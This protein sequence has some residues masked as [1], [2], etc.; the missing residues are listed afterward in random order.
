MS[1]LE[2]TLDAPEGWSEPAIIAKLGQFAG[3]MTQGDHPF[4]RASHA[5]G[6][7]FHLRTRR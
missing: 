2:P 5:T 3:H 6:S 1:A 7:G 4:S